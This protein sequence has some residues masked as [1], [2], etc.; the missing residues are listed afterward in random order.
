VAPQDRQEF[1]GAL[2]AHAREATDSMWAART[3]DG[4]G[5]D[6]K[7][8]APTIGLSSFDLD[9]RSKT[10]TGFVEWPD[11]RAA[12]QGLFEVLHHEYTINSA[13]RLAPPEAP[14]NGPFRVQVIFEPAPNEAPYIKP[15]AS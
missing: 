3:K 11:A 7:K 8:L 6:L 5:T 2:D 1:S 4:L 14:G 12:R 10:C 15:S 13:V 9:C